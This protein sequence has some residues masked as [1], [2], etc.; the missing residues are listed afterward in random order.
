MYDGIGPQ[1]IA[2]TLNSKICSANK[3]IVIQTIYI[4]VNLSTG[5]NAHKDLVINS[6]KFLECL[7]TILV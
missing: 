1:K 4:A 3:D 7:K 5:S 2:N 6:L